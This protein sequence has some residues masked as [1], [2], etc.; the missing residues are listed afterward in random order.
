MKKFD[1]LIE[2][3]WRTCK[4]HPRTHLILRFH[5]NPYAVLH[6][7]SCINVASTLCTSDVEIAGIHDNVYIELVHLTVPSYQI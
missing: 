3:S 5:P 4:P 6:I 2:F 1:P 7:Y